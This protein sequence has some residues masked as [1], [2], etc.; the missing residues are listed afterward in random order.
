MSSELSVRDRHIPPVVLAFLAIQIGQLAYGFSREVRDD[1]HLPAYVLAVVLGALWV[2]AIVVW[3]QRWAWWLYVIGGF[4]VLASPVWGKWAG[5]I[6]Y[7]LNVVV[8][9][10]ILSHT[11]RQYVG[12]RRRTHAA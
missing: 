11:M 5:V 8:M 7:S 9:A 12:I 3:R 6:R 1:R 10:L 4:L 2:A